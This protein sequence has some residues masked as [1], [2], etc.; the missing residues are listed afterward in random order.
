MPRLDPKKR[1]RNF[2]EVAL[3]YSLEQAQEEA[4]RCIQCHK[5]FC[6]EGCPVGGDIS[7][8]Y[9]GYWQWRSA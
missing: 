2:N 7:W 4:N 3:G 9:Q 6:I 5:H 1:I 8:F